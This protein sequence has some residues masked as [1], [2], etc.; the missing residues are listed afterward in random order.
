[1]V[2]CLS[3]RYLAELLAE[4]HKLNPFVPVLPH[5][6]R[7]LNQGELSSNHAICVMI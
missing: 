4:R 3:T 6:I 1:M 5:S 2:L 7:L